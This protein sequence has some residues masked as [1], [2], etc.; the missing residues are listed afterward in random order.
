MVKTKRAPIRSRP[1]L[2]LA[3][4]AALAAAAVG[5]AGQVGAA[6]APQGS[7]TIKSGAGPGWP[8]TL[9]P[10]DFVAR[11]DNPWFPLQPGSRWHYRGVDADGR[12]SDVMHVD[13]PDQE[14]RGRAGDRGPRRGP[15][16]RQAARG[17]RRLV[18]AGSP[19]QRLVFRREHEGARP[20]RP[21]DEPRGLVQSWARRRAAGGSVPGSP[22][23]GTKARQ[24]Y[25]KGHAEDHF[26]DL[27]RNARVSVPYVSSHDAVKTKEWTPLEPGVVEHKYY[28]RGVGDVKE[29]TVKGPKERLRLVS[30]HSGWSGPRRLCCPGGRCRRCWR[31]NGRRVTRPADGRVRCTYSRSPAASMASAR[32]SNHS[33]RIALPSRNVKTAQ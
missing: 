15:E 7:Q 18:R 24:E 14:D 22:T 2:A 20:A 31:H 11:V 28:V 33:T 19:R 10:N 30:F 16:A 27:D 13:A 4:A 5:G 6:P 23:G 8:K 26:K 21:R 9:H 29:V 32:A 1:A 25:Y 3:G 17:H 12:F